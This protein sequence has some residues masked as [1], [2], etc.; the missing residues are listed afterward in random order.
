MSREGGRG[1]RYR[2]AQLLGWVMVLGVFAL[3][4]ASF[5]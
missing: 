4:A 2:V 3:L 5:W 1:L